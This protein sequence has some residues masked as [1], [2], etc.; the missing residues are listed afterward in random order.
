MSVPTV[1]YALLFYVATAILVAGLAF[2][3]RQYWVTPAPLKIPVTPAPLTRAGVVMRLAWEVIFFRSLFFSNKWTWLFGVLF[4]A[5]LLLIVLRHLRYFIETNW[6]LIVLAQPFGMYAG[7][8]L[9]LGLLG[10][11]ARRL[12]VDRVRYVTSLSDHL[13]LALIIGIGLSGLSL[14]YLAR[15][16]IVQVKMFFLGLLR[17][18]IQPL[19][20][21]PMLL[22]H[23]GLVITLMIVFPFSKL[24]HAPGIFFHPSRNQV[25]DA[26]EK[27]HLADWARPLDAEREK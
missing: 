27:R 16:D 14:R 2:K 6:L 20:E 25:D 1:I 17:F 18:N 23:L 19:P 11:W 3:I 21:D 24:L 12:F 22:L 13:M 4:H 7:F 10:L 26:R 8:S 9:V 15:T 5:S